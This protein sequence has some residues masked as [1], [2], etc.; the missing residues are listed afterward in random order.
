MQ[1]EAEIVTRQGRSKVRVD[2][3]NDARVGAVTD[4]I[5]QYLGEPEGSAVRVLDRVGV[6]PRSDEPMATSGIRRGDALELASGSERRPGS[7]LS[8]A[9][10]AIPASD[11][12]TPKEAGTTRPPDRFL[13]FDNGVRLVPVP[14]GSGG[15]SGC[16]PIDIERGRLRIGRDPSNE[17][18]LTDRSVSRRH[19]AIECFP[20]GQVTIEDLGSTGGVLLNGRPIGG[21]ASIEPGDHLQIGNLVFCAAAIEGPPAVDH[22]VLSFRAPFMAPWP[23]LPE[24]QFDAP[25]AAANRM[26]FPWI[27]L[28]V[29][30]LMAAV[31]FGVSGGAPS[32]AVFY[33]MSPLFLIGTLIEQQRSGGRE[34]TRARSAWRTDNESRLT[35]LAESIAKF[36]Q[37][38]EIRCP[39]PTAIESIAVRRTAALWHR[40]KGEPEFL[41]LR[42]GTRRFDA[43]DRFGVGSGGDLGL[44][45]ELAAQIDARSTVSTCPLGFSLSAIGHLG[46]CGPR[47][48][49]VA[50]AAL[51]GA[52]TLHAPAD[53]TVAAIAD[54]DAGPS[55]WDWLAWLPHVRAAASVSGAWMLASRDSEEDVDRVLGKVEELVEG[56]GRTDTS[57][58]IVLVDLTGRDG[59]PVADRVRTRGGHLMSRS[60]SAGAHVVW[61]T[62]GPESLPASCSAVVTTGG[63]HQPAK[64]TLQ[65]ATYGD[66]DWW[67]PMSRLSG[68]DTAA[69]GA[70]PR[71][72]SS[73]TRP[74]HPG[75]LVIDDV[76][77]DSMS[78]A[79][80]EAIARALAP[81]IDPDRPGSGHDLPSLV[82]VSELFRSASGS[83]TLDAPQVAAAWRR[84]DRDAS[85][86]V[87]IGLGDTGPITI[88][89][90]R[91]GPHALVAG[92]TGSGKSEL[93]QSMVCG[94]AARY[95]PAHLNFLFVD[96]KGGAAFRECVDLP[97][98]VGC[99][100]NLDPQEVRRVLTSLNAELD[101]RM[102]A[103]G[104]A[105]MKDLAT[106]EQLH[107]AR[108]GNTDSSTGQG[109]GHVAGQGTGH[110]AGQGDAPFP[111]LVLVVDEFAALARELPAFVDGVLDISQRGRSLGIH[112]VLATQRPRGVITDAI[113]ANTNLRIALRTA[114]ADESM[115]VLGSALAAGLPHT[116][117]GRAVLRIGA[118]E[119]TPFQSAFAGAPVADGATGQRIL[120]SPLTCAPCPAQLPRSIGDAPELLAIIDA[121]RTA[122]GN[123]GLPK[124]RRPWLE[125]LP[126]SLPTL[127]PSTAGD[128][129]PA[130]PR[131]GFRRGV[132]E[133]G[134]T[135]LPEHQA[136]A[137][138][139]IDLDEL[140]HLGIYGSSGTGKTSFLRMIASAADRS[141]Q[142][143]GLAGRP[144][145]IPGEG[146]CV[147][148][149]GIDATGALSDLARLAATGGVVR[150]SAIG[151]I[152]RLLRMITA[153]IEDRGT[154][155]AQ[156]GWADWNAARAERPDLPR[157]IL[158][159]DGIGAFVDR[160]AKVDGGV[161]IDRLSAIASTGRS[162]GVHLIFTADTKGA[163]PPALTASV[164]GRMVFALANPSESTALDQQPGVLGATAPPGRCSLDGIHQTQLLA[165]AG[166]IEAACPGVPPAPGVPE[167]PR[168][169]EIA[170]GWDLPPAS[171]RIPVGV[172]EVDAQIASIV[173]RPATW[174]VCGPPRSGRTTVL[175]M[176]CA[177]M[178]RSGAGSVLY[179]GS[180]RGATRFTSTAESATALAASTT[181]RRSGAVSAITDEPSIARALTS[182]LEAAASRSAVD[183][184]LVIDDLSERSAEVQQA[185]TSL[186]AVPR[187]G[188]TVLAGVDSQRVDRYSEAWRSLAAGGDGA[189]LQPSLERDGSLLDV[190]L[191]LAV[192]EDLN[193]PGRGF[194]VERGRAPEFVQLFA[195][196]PSGVR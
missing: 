168:H 129:H 186:L 4:A 125:P 47:A 109:T 34:F 146:E 69:D 132:I 117:P 105:G 119:P 141:T 183:L 41:M 195:P 27:T 102:R 134:I 73:P 77:I 85:L 127:P 49:E 40:S 14:T 148:V 126:T 84:G 86:S 112:L 3:P 79:E 181:V 9:N 162:V 147:H 60:A 153:R 48:R 137:V 38:T 116:S 18:V 161:W 175:A 50:R 131:C 108:P 68:S 192:D 8:P 189:L 160:F 23:S 25:P 163:V 35:G 57:R 169:S 156:C 78:Q 180:P 61:L 120:V 5:S 12:R 106:W 138:A 36:A 188:L 99:V 158:M 139:K 65:G 56:R 123:M 75:A 130:S 184:I 174:C 83:G 66:L 46:I 88:D 100:T 96:Y 52:V 187:P 91:D 1:L 58:L 94:L 22:D 63:P 20:Y 191:P 80:A 28:G 16:S 113:R 128:G 142:L 33:A 118:G 55:S 182:I 42:L 92:T 178:L 101:R 64:V 26:A 30:L 31:M 135:D 71:P 76:Q 185:I 103:I 172:R 59:T 107:G 159:V 19:C 53:V 176:T 167:F 81:I 194:L 29:G 72:G 164:K 179:L 196:P 149:Y 32:T 13:T 51:A 166:R 24:M 87:P 70:E 144:G 133:V 44:R 150:C 45:A 90:R 21:R 165:P 190:M 173:D 140:G 115:D 136:R 122:A 145:E 154:Q 89:L 104:Q 67:D 155:F 193:V 110:V 177:A 171:D 10:P 111:S 170:E 95:S 11:Q 54:L 97:H 121:A 74:P 6:R 62:D 15:L 7:A 39:S 114:D 2:Y 152:R 151:D 82:T 43:S 37:A 93:L 124:L 143:N 98:S 157:T 17:L